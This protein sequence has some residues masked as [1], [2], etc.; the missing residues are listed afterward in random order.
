MGCRGRCHL[1]PYWGWGEEHLASKDVSGPAGER[2]SH[3]QVKC[4]L[5][6][7]NQA[8]CRTRRSGTGSPGLQE[9]R[10]HVPQPNISILRMTMAKRLIPSQFKT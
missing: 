7:S 5:S 9:N 3:S 1:L 10:Y 2:K 4:F 8:N 6:P